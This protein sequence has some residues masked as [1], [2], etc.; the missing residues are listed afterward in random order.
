MLLDFWLRGLDWCV[1]FLNPLCEFGYG[2]FTRY[3]ILDRVAVY[4]VNIVLVRLQS[5][6]SYQ[7]E[8]GYQIPRRK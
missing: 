6:Q 1:S 2:I 7:L 8:G 5:L 4:A 3:A